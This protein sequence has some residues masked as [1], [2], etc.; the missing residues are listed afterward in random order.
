MSGLQDIL[1]T[2]KKKLI[3]DYNAPENYPDQQ[4]AE[5]LN[6]STLNPVGPAPSSA[7]PPPLRLEDVKTFHQLKEWMKQNLEIWNALEASM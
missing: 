7:N 4:P 5:K 3:S 1:D 2:P 6:L